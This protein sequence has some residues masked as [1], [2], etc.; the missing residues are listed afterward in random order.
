MQQRRGSGRGGGGGG[1]AW[2]EADGDGTCTYDALKGQGSGVAVGH[3]AALT[4]AAGDH[5]R[6][7]EALW[8]TVEHSGRALRQSTALSTAQLSI[9]CVKRHAR[10]AMPV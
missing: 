5:L 8:Y 3:P 4:T 7:V 2:A 9:A 1:G 10:H 6:S